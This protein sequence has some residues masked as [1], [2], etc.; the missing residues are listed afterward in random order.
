MYYRGWHSFSLVVYRHIAYT[1]EGVGSWIAIKLEDIQNLARVTGIA[2]SAKQG[3]M[4][5]AYFCGVS[6]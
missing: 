4:A 1:N 5:K 6:F 2:R 3:H